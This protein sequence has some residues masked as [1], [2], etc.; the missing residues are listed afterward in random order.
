MCSCSVTVLTTNFRFQFGSDLPKL[1]LVGIVERTCV[2]TIVREIPHIADCFR[3]REDNKDGRVKVCFPSLTAI[4]SVSCHTLSSAGHDK[5]LELQGHVAFRLQW[6]G[7][8]DR[9]G[10]NLLERHLRHSDDLRSRDG[11]CGHCARNEWRIRRVQNRRRQSPSRAHCRLH[12]Q[13]LPFSST[14]P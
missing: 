1:L 6:C 11:S 12:G 4:M 7:K 3:V 14:S 13:F 8:H 2:K 9:R 5:R 10:L